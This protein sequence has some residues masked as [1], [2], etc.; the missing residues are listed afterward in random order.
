[1]QFKGFRAVKRGPVPVTGP[2]VPL[3]GP[4]VP[5][6]GPSVLLTGALS[7]CLIVG[8]SSGFNC[9]GLQRASKS[10][11]RGDRPASEVLEDRNLLK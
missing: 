2:S 10:L 4:S 3:T 7:N 11:G 1:M 6:T 9:I 8:H 5:L